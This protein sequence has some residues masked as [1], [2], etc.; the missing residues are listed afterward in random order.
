MFYMAFRLRGQ[1]CS[2]CSTWLSVREDRS[3]LNVHGFL[4][5]RIGVFSMFRTAAPH[6][7]YYFT[8]VTIT[9]L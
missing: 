6:T 2:E 1:E 8:V 3:V 7:T 5:E 9:M 4:F